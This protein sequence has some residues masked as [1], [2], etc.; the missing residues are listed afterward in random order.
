MIKLNLP[1]EL[2]KAADKRI[3]L[4]VTPAAERALR[5][6][7]PWLFDQAI[8]HQSHQ[9]NAGDLAVIFDKK[10]RFLAI[11]LYDPEAMIRVRILQHLKPAS[12]NVDWFKAR[13]EAA[14]QLRAPLSN[15]P[16]N[17]LTN[18]YRLVHGENDGV[19]G[20]IVDRYHDIAV[21]KIYTSAW[22][23]H[24]KN[25]VSALEDIF[26]FKSVVLRLG[27]GV[28]ENEYNLRDGMTLV[29]KQTDQPLTFHENGL[30]FEVDPVHGQ[31]TGFFLD[32]RENRARVE[33]LAKGKSVLN[34][35]SYTGGFSV[36]AARGGAKFVVSLDASKPAL[37]AAVRNFNLNLPPP[38]P[39]VGQGENL[40]LPSERGRPGAG[41]SVHECVNGDAFE[42][43]TQM[44][45]KG[46][47]FEMVI[48][49]PPSFAKKESQIEGAISAYKKLTRLGLSILEPGGIL[50][51]AS[52]SSRVDAE[53]FFGA[54]NQAAIQVRRP[55]KE[56]ERSGHAL[57]HPVTFREGEYLKCL[58]AFAP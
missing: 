47:Q 55:L 9:G 15:S 17:K 46:H 53:T 1:S 20:L 22:I 56:I 21:I 11:G 58:F 2:P 10:R 3:A 26:P 35:F 25:V 34:A 44:K 52:C 29:G 6:G 38:T 13:L 5:Q 7:H 4:R 19:P 12:I 42:E 24:L 16:P 33:K 28:K 43:M 37:E 41:A 8:I 39:S 50:V 45:K 32:Q 30:Q 48:I 36:Y 31:K 23:P 49:D 57:D 54:V 51:Q 40:L 27:G 14:S 18:A